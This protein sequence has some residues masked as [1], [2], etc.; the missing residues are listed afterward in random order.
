MYGLR[1]LVNIHRVGRRLVAWVAELYSSLSEQI[2]KAFRPGH[3]N[4]NSFSFWVRTG[5][6]TTSRAG[7]R[8]GYP[9]PVFGT[10]ED[11]SGH[12]LTRNV[13]AQQMQRFVL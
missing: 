6:L 5:T 7:A 11:F 4:Q 3:T 9:A 12:A 8:G 10:P 1:L 13:R 2:W